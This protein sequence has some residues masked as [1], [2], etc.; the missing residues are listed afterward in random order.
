MLFGRLDYEARFF[1]LRLLVPLLSEHPDAESYSRQLGDAR[2]DL[3][4]WLAQ[5]VEALPTVDHVLREAAASESL[6]CPAAKKSRRQK[7]REA[8]KRP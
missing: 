8:R 7:R 6:F 1:L 2:A 3:A 5:L 4:G